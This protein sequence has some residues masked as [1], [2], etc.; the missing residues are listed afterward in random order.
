MREF[1]HKT[2][3]LALAAALVLALAACGPKEGAVTPEPDPS[4]SPSPSPTQAVDDLADAGIDFLP[5][6]A[7]DV[8][9]ITLG[10][11]QSTAL[12]TVNGTAVTA[13]EYLY[14]L[15][16]M[17]DYY[18]MMMMYSGSALDLD[19][20][21]DE[22]G[23]TW[24]A[25]LKEVA[26]ENAVL[27]AVAK[28]AAAQN[29]VSLDD[30]DKESLVQQRSERITS[31]GDE[32]AYAK[33][34]QDRGINDKTLYRMDLRAALLD[35][36]QTAYTEKV[37]AAGN[38]A[39]ITDQEMA[40]YLE[41]NGLLRAKH[42]LLLTKDP[43]TNEAYDDAKKAQQKAKAEDILA[44][45]RADPA[46]FDELMNAN[47]EDTGL[48][49][50]PDG[51]LFGPGEMVTEFESGTRALAEGEISD[52]VES[53]FGYHIILR[54]SADCEESRGELATSKFNDMMSQYVDNAAVEK[55]PEYES[56]NTKTYYQALTTFRQSRQEPETQDQSSATLQPAPA[57]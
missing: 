42:I 40:A 20:A 55:A 28:E 3:A 27:L 51:Y 14:W 49:S 11:P 43:N 18:S 2:L 31:A 38:E 33:Q 45:L 23:T 24:G 6:N 30:S 13:E 34:L 26:Y 32:T 35:K 57:Q 44:Q 48:Q 53:T 47:S 5:D 41:E 16:N 37:L 8:T 54:L 9:Q 22:T 50:Y 39:S 19:A 10:F 52:I 15:A 21:I 56:L 12:L 29:G 25:Q 36:L 4:A 17:T 46:K 1:F 7:L